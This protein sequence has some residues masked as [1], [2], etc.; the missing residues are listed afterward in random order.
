M[1]LCCVPATQGQSRPGRNKVYPGSSLWNRL[2]SCL[3][4]VHWMTA[5][6]RQNGWHI[7]SWF[8]II[9]GT[10]L[11]CAFLAGLPDNL[12]RLLWTPW[13]LD[14]LGIDQLLARTW[15]I[16]KDMELLATAVGETNIERCEADNPMFSNH[17]ETPNVTDAGPKPFL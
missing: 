4:T 9:I 14:E 5:W 1:G 13:R 10:F 2:I 3:E 12:S 7:L 17:E 15:S 6:P 16:L 8:K 11:G